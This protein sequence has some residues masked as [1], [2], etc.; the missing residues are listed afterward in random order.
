[1]AHWRKMMDSRYIGSW[2]IDGDWTGTISN[3]EGGEVEG[4]GGTKQKKP[5]I[6]FKEA[7][8]KLVCGATICKTIAS[9]TGSNNVDD[10]I[11]QRITL[12][13]TETQAFGDVVECVRVRPKA[14]K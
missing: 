7:K 11:G 14:P 3:V 2:D 4:Q 6:T 12:Y 9:I 5:L 1:M 10:W 13:V 8:K